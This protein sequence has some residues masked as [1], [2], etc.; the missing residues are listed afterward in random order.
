MELHLFTKGPRKFVEFISIH[1][2]Y[3]RKSE[4]KGRVKHYMTDRLTQTLT[5]NKNDLG[6]SKGITSDIEERQTFLTALDKSYKKKTAEPQ[7]KGDLR[8]LKR[9][10]DKKEAELREKEAKKKRK[11]KKKK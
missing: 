10:Q 3:E 9:I 2:S 5:E 4:A 8:D 6:V 1:E 11:T 7:R